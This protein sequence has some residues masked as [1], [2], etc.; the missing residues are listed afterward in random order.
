MVVVVVRHQSVGPMC[1]PDAAA[2]C[3]VSEAVIQAWVDFARTGDPNGSSELQAQANQLQAQHH[4]PQ[5]P[6]EEVRT[7]AA[8]R[9]GVLL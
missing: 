9:A 3:K 5:Q 1:S 4:H 8:W 6:A 2:N 7:R